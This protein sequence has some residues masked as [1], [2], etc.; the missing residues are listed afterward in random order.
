[1]TASVDNTLAYMDQGSFLGLRA[2]QRGPVIQYT[3]IYERAVDID[4]LRRFQRN[5]EHTLLGRLIE[6]SPLPFGRHRWVAAGPPEPIDIS[7]I[8]RR[9]D[10]IG[11][12]ADERSQIPTD[13]ED[14]PPWHLGVQPLRDGGAAVTLV[15]S[16]SI[17]DAAALTMSIAAA[18]EGRALGPGYP[19]RRHRPYRQA[20]ADDLRTTIRSAAA[21]PSAVA[22]SVRTAREQKQDLSESVKSSAP[23]LAGHSHRPVV[24][25]AATAYIAY[26][27]WQRVS[28]ELGGTPNALFAGLAARL[29]R[30]LGRVDADGMAMLTFPVS[31]RTEDDTRANALTAVTVKADPDTVTT[32]LSVV[33]GDLKAALADLAQTREDLLAPLPL[34]PFTPKFL[35]RRLERMVMQVGRPIGCSNTGDMPEAVNRPDGTD[36]DYFSARQVERGVS[37]S[38]LERMEGCLL[39]GWAHAGDKVSVTFGSWQP[40]GVNTKAA[41]RES[42]TRV[43]SDFGLSGTVE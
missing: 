33:R 38:A 11:E 29:G 39:L 40:G 35:V 15:V 22:G 28:A 14:G 3:W 32:D 25:P 30:A 6:R 4:G 21:V 41:L 43:L 19:P 31:E 1:M 16:H 8:D 23:A 18:V 36:A 20:L 10:E 17:V 42:V 34:T 37:L 5:L 24:I 12:W 9:R 27:D 7:V 2:L 26:S 13:P